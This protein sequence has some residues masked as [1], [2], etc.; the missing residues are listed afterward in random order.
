M[1]GIERKIA[2]FSQPIKRVVSRM[3]ADTDEAISAALDPLGEIC[4]KYDGVL[5]I[6]KTSHDLIDNAQL[7][8]VDLYSIVDQENSGLV[9][10]RN[11]VDLSSAVR[12]TKINYVGKQ[13]KELKFVKPV[14]I[15]YITQVKPIAK[16]P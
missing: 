13:F 12:T 7:G 2:S 9:M 8:R 10:V 6:S 3:R 16:L 14:S 1:A 15:I 4:K 5:E 11:E